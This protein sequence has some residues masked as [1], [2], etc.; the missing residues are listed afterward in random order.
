MNTRNLKLHDWLKLRV[1][2]ILVDIKA[3]VFVFE[4]KP[5]MNAPFS[6]SLCFE[7]I[8]SDCQI[9]T[10]PD[11]STLHLKHKPLEPIDMKELGSGGIFNLSNIVPFKR[12][13]GR[14]LKQICSIYSNHE[15]QEIGARLVFG[16]NAE[17]VLINNGDE[18]KFFDKIPSIIWKEGDL[19][20]FNI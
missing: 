15:N 20:Y 9:T 5:D 17:L 12:V 6:I 7:G 16:G 19:S 1:G 18:L 10:S 14:R 4:G 8:L 2:L 11:G 13:I 3:L